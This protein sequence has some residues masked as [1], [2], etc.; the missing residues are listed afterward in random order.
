MEL[1]MYCT[2]LI[3]MLFT[4]SRADIEE[5]DLHTTVKDSDIVCDNKKGDLKT[6]L[7]VSNE[8][9]Q[10]TFDFEKPTWKT[11]FV[12][13]VAGQNLHVSKTVLALVSPYFEREFGRKRNNESASMNLT[14]RNT[15]DVKEFLRCIYPNIMSPVTFQNAEMILPSAHE[16]E[17]AQLKQTC[18]QVLIESISS[19]TDIDRIFKLL[20]KAA[21]YGLDTLSELCLKVAS[22][23]PYREINKASKKIDL[24]DSL[25]ANIF[26]R[27]L[28]SIHESAEGMVNALADDNNHLYIDEYI[29]KTLNLKVKNLDQCSVSQNV[30]ATDRL[31]LKVTVFVS[32]FYTYRYIF[33]R[34]Y[35]TLNIVITETRGTTGKV[36]TNFKG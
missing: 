31:A 26:E 5:I 4:T 22:S 18:E 10:P 25:K 15:E 16:F 35:N 14:N 17:V 1:N 3:L 33:P 2:Y 12:I 20:Q 30:T 32:S 19:D 29:G 24:M 13:N 6:C 21:T 7:N 28:I 23:K 9:D 27:C 36:F 34:S 11:D 8:V